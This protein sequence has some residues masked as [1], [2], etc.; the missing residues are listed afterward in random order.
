[1]L[2]SWLVIILVFL[3]ALTAIGEG[4]GDFLRYYPFATNSKPA[5]AIATSDKIIAVL[6]MQKEE[7][8]QWLPVKF[9]TESGQEVSGRVSVQHW[10]LDALERDGY[11]TV[12]YLA[13]D[14][15]RFLLEE[16]VQEISNGYGE[17][18]FGLLFLVIGVVLVPR[19][20]QLARYTKYLGGGG[21]N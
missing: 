19:R 8:R 6:K 14:P 18:A 10:A 5:K 1:M 15:Q 20:Y 2:K 9:T 4:L 7:E 16:S 12:F 21:D 17:L 13:D 3:M 11:I